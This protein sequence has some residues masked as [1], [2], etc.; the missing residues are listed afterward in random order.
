MNRVAIWIFGTVSGILLVFGVMIVSAHGGYGAS[1]SCGSDGPNPQPCTPTLQYITLNPLGGGGFFSAG[2]MVLLLAILIGLPAWIASPILAQR[3]SSSARTA[4]LIVSIIASA[5]VIVS[6]AVPLF[7][8]PAL[9]TPATCLGSSGAG[10]PC[11]YG[12]AAK[13]VAVLGIGLGPLVA[14][15]FMGMPAWVMALT[16]TSRRKRWGWF[17]AVLF[18]SP[19]AAMLYGFFGARSHPSDAPHA[20]TLAAA[21]A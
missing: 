1:S 7:S 12:A 18:F 15:L 8:S 20:P 2:L 5:L 13:L 6:L 16:E 17:V 21:G 9:S 10:Q 14:S 4:I 19:I 3:R 11:I